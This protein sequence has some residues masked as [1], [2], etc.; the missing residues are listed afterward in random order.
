MFNS[1]TPGCEGPLPA[2]TET[3]RRLE[4]LKA[5]LEQARPLP[6]ATALSLRQDL[7]LR[8]TYNSNAIEGNTLTL[9]ETKV[10]VEDGL[11]I[12]GKTV[13]EHLEAIGHQEAI[14]FIEK[15]A[16]TPAPLDERGLK[17]IH[18][19]V[20]KSIDA[21]NAG[22]WREQDV[23][24]SGAEHRPPKAWDVPEKMRE[25][26]KWCGGDV[27]QK[28]HPVE[29]AARVHAD[30]VNIHPFIDGNGRTARLIMNLELLKAGYP[31][32]IV[33]VEE[34][35]A[36]YDNLDRIATQGDYVPFTRQVAALVEK[37]F[38]MYFSII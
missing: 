22:R 29:R 32:A 20:L 27:P 31:L 18:S 11:T 16:Q 4:T 37:G 1:W 38:E 21:H 3:Y 30:F 7:A 24:I 28:I 14:E 26:F 5:R 33:P 8:Y 6:P 17:D 34:R 2:L 19:L 10:V 23:F 36:Y 15:L 35:F 25:F 13:R 9:K 12:G